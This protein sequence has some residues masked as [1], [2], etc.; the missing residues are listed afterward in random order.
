MPP[1]DEIFASGK[2]FTSPEEAVYMVQKTGIDWLS[3]AFSITFFQFSIIII[4]LL[5]ILN[6]LILLCIY[7]NERYPQ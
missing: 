3:V 7:K 2:G 1:Y 5:S 4:R 6:L